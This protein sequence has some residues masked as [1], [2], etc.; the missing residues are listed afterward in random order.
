MRRSFLGRLEAMSRR[1]GLKGLLPFENSRVVAKDVLLVAG[2]L[3]PVIL[4]DT[5]TETWSH[6]SFLLDPSTLG[7]STAQL[8]V[9][10]A[11]RT[12]TPDSF[13]LVSL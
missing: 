6:I 4:S 5:A 11:A 12:A 2:A 13:R 3:A 7:R 8:D 1:T 10:Q 9:I